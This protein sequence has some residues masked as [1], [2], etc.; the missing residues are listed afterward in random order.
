MEEYLPV[1]EKKFHRLL[2]KE[3]IERRNAHGTS[4]VYHATAIIIAVL[5]D[6][7]ILLADKTEKEFEIG[8]LQ[9][10]RRRKQHEGQ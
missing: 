8:Q 2:V 3:K 7:K 9:R 5:P 10:V 6:G 1:I 4:P